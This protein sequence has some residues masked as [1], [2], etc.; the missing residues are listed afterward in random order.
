MARSA[1]MQN[2]ALAVA[3]GRRCEKLVTNT[4]AGILRKAELALRRWS[5]A[6]WGSF[7]SYA[8]RVIERDEET[9]Q[10]YMVT[11]PHNGPVT[12]RKIADRQR[13]AIAGV[14][15]VCQVCGLHYYYQTDPRGYALWVSDEPLNDQNYIKGVPC[16]GEHEL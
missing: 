10:P 13:L 5:E 11:Y 16:H 9:G 1:K 8:G 14:V 15:D 2:S 4:E 12:K 3:I 7:D 6:E